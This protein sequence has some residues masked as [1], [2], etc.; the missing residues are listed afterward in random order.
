MR[1]CN[2]TCAR[3]LLLLLLLSQPL[4]NLRRWSLMVTLRIHAV[5]PILLAVSI[6]GPAAFH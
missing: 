1:P 5:L 6:Q 4:L 2:A 3:A